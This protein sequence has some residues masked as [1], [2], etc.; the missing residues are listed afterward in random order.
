MIEILSETFTA[1]ETKT[2]M[3]Q[4]GY[5]EILDALY[6]VNVYLMDR[7][8][9]QISTMRNAEASFFSRPGPFECIQINS[10][11]AQTVRLFV[12]SGDAGTRRAS[13]VV[14]VVDGETARSK[15]AMAFIATAAQAPVAAQFSAVQ[16]WNPAG[17]GRRLIV[18]E[19]CF[20]SSVAAAYELRRYAAVLPAGVA[21]NLA[22]KLVN[23]A[24]ATVA[25]CWKAAQAAHGGNLIE[26]FD[27][28]ASTP[29]VRKLTQPYVLLPGNGL[30]VENNIANANAVASFQYYEETI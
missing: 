18:S 9:G 29:F 6:P 5:I 16:L 7:S 11:Q 20:S 1:N 21:G 17:T 12:G 27:V 13:G 22:S 15:A 26:T 25:Q 19:L 14:Q 30:N 28:A 3:F 4:G 23:D 24:G 8:G 10:P 2:F